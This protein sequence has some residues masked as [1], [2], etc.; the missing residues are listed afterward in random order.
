MTSNI[1]LQLHLNALTVSQFS[2]IS[3]TVRSSSTAISKKED[4]D[5][6]CILGVLCL[7]HLEYYCYR[8]RTNNLSKAKMGNHEQVGMADEQTD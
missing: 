6:N 1:S 2:N 8:S 7:H 5:L 3:Y 4:I